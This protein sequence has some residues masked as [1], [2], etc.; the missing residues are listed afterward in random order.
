MLDI[1]SLRKDLDAVV[2]RLQTR[3]NPQPFLDVE[4]FQSLEHERKG[5]QVRTEE[6]QAKRNS[7]SKQLSLIHISE[8]TRPY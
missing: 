2:A 5:L 1:T 6:L 4:A 8:P 7:L 3:K